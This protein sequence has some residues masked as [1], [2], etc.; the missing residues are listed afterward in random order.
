MQEHLQQSRRYLD[1]FVVLL[2]NLIYGRDLTPKFMSIITRIVDARKSADKQTINELPG[3]AHKY[4]Y[5]FVRGL[6]GSF[7]P[8]YFTQSINRLKKFGLYTEIAPVD[9]GNGISHNARIV[10]EHINSSYANTKKK[11]VLIG[12]SKGKTIIMLTKQ[13]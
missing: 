12:H 5:V 13:Y 8:F 9:T 3:D 2:T 10:A 11:V 4:S 7:G 1:S 6:F